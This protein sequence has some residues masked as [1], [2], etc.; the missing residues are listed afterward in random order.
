MPP[1]L[2]ALLADFEVG[3]V[4]TDQWNHRAHLA[5]AA[6]AVFHV[7]DPLPWLRE[8]LQR[9]LRK[10]GHEKNPQR[11]YHETLTAG[12]LHRIGVQLAW[13]TGDFEARCAT[14]VDALSDKRLLLRYWSKQALMS[15]EARTIWCP[16]DLLPLPRPAPPPGPEEWPAILREVLQALRWP[17]R[18]EPLLEPDPADP[19]ALV[20]G[21]TPGGVV[22]VRIDHPAAAVT[23]GDKHWPSL[24]GWLGDPV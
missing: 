1:D 8:R 17:M 20:L 23:I 10:P 13:E 22:R 12:W 9:L 5:V 7:D 14:T 18:L 16:P 19:G 21:L 3:D 4:S 6:W 11:S 2:P 24:E 15:D